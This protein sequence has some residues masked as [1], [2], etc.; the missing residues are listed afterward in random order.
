MKTLKDFDFEGKRVLVRCDFN[1]SIDKNGK[2]SEKYRIKNTIPTI[3]YLMRQ[4][5]KIILMSHLSEG[6][7]KTDSL[8]PVA[9]EL[10]K[11]LKKKIMFLPDCLGPEAKKASQG[12]HESQIMLVENVRFYPEEKANDE[13]FAR[14]LSQ[15]GDIF[16]NEAFSV[17][18]RKHASVMG[19]NR[20]L[21]SCAGLLLEKEINTL[22]KIL[23]DFERPLIVIIGGV[24]LESKIKTML[25]FLKIADHLLLGSKIGEA[26]LI[27]K[28]LLL[29]REPMEKKF[30]SQID[31]TSPKIHLPIDGHMALKDPKESYSRKGAIGTLKRE[32]EIFDIGPETIKVFK[33]IIKEG[34]T[35]FWSGPV[36]LFEDKRF[37]SGTKETG[38]A[39]VRNF[40]AF[41]VAGGG[42]TISALAKFHLQDKF[43]FVSTGGG[44]M[45]EFLGGGELP[46]IKALD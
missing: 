24:K 33:E 38:E 3:K 37:A 23:N 36:G 28:G 7:K 30:V 18:H 10:E 2:I 5:A 45:L 11:I 14:E 34:R 43:D 1:V 6:D 42:D 22:N 4:G 19:I 29:G 16:V 13:A 8:R 46:G 44:A 31:L 32:E 21:P 17:C 35:I 40:R 15:L 12:L 26:I 41:K 25:N 20:F 27:H 9:Q 39:V